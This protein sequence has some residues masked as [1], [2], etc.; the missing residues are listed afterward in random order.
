MSVVNAVSLVILLYPPN[1][2]DVV[3]RQ[4]IQ[5]AARSQSKCG[6]EECF[7][8]AL[9]IGTLRLIYFRRITQ[10]SN[11]SVQLIVQEAQLFH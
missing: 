4:F 8:S 7:R 10:N 2:F 9:H 6:S 5:F 1:A 3:I 11:D